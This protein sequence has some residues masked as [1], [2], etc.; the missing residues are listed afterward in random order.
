MLNAKSV[1]MRTGNHFTFRPT[2]LAWWHMSRAQAQGALL[3]A[4]FA[5]G[6]VVLVRLLDPAGG[7]AAPAI[8]FALYAC[9]AAASL[10]AMAPLGYPRD[11]YGSP[12]AV[13]LFRL[14]LV[15]SLAGALVDQTLLDRAGLA[16]FA[17][18]ASA[19]ALDGLDGWLARHHSVP[20]AYGARF[21]MEVDAGLACML[22]LVLLVSE[23]AG[24]ELLILGFSRYAFLAAGF[25]LGWL[26]A[27]LPDRLGRKGVCVIQIG[28]LCLLL[29]PVFTD[30]TARAIALGAAA[31]LVWSFGRDIRYLARQR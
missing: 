30:Q 19:L 7:I 4:F 13:T 16:I 6:V 28:A 11:V 18:A 5:V 24:P 31:L 20:S 12:N 17:V 8:A 29:L 3:A 27:P 26:R 10:Y 25:L 22:A 14:A 2:V 9:A 15:C 21:D 23:R 1:E